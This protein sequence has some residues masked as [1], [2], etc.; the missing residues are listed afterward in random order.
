MNPVP[1]EAPEAFED[2][3][4][5]DMVFS[6]SELKA[7]LR[8]AAEQFDHWGC[9]EE[10]GGVRTVLGDLFPDEPQERQAYEPGR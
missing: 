5:R 3:S 6:A 2:T 7:Y 10:A 4:N 8:A 9:P 1:P